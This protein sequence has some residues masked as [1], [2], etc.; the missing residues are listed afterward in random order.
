MHQRIGTK[1][2]L[3]NKLE[4]QL[5]EIGHSLCIRFGL[6]EFG[7]RFLMQSSLHYC[8][9]VNTGWQTF[10]FNHNAVTSLLTAGSLK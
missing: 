2:S 10:L 3:R 5:K 1:T 4:I 8:I 9:Q 7:Y 6:E